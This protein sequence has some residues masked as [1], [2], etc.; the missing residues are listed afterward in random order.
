[1]HQ[2]STMAADE[3]FACSCSSLMFWYS[4]ETRIA[5]VYFSCCFPWLNVIMMRCFGVVINKYRIHWKKREPVDRQNRTEENRNS[6]TIVKRIEQN[7]YFRITIV[8]YKFRLFL[9]MGSFYICTGKYN[10]FLVLILCTM[11]N[12]WVSLRHTFQF[13]SAISPINIHEPNGNYF[14]H[15]M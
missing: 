8:R 9:S 3:H 10:C 7:E 4:L 12:L 5:T 6:V 15:V 13:Y 11:P 1:M 2:N 14:R